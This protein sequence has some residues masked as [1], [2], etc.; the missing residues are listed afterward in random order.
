WVRERSQNTGSVML[1]AAD[2]FRRQLLRQPLALVGLQ[3]HSVFSP[4]RQVSQDG[5]AEHDRRESLEQK[6]PLPTGESKK[7]IESNQRPGERTTDHAGDWN[8]YYEFRN[9]ASARFGREPFTEIED[10]ARKETGFRDAEEEP[11]HIETR[12]STDKHHGG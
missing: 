10:H 8:G 3:P 9:G 11:E 5:H 7:A 6:K 4:V 12:G 1:D 2:A